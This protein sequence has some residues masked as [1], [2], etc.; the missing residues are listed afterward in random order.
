[1][2]NKQLKEKHYQ[3]NTKF[4]DTTNAP[5]W[6]RS[7]TVKKLSTGMRKQDIYN[8]PKME[9]HAP[10]ALKCEDNVKL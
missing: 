5:T 4:H 2:E 3:S 10:T 1:L 9:V 7:L 8:W 6:C